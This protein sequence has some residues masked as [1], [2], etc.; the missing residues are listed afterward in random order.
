MVRFD[1]INK[2]ITTA[3]IPRDVLAKSTCAQSTVPN[4]YV[5]INSIA[6]QI[7]QLPDKK[8]T[9]N[10]GL[11]CLVDSLDSNY[12]IKINEVVRVNFKAVIDLVDQ[13]GGLE[14]APDP[15][16][17]GPGAEAGFCAQDEYGL[18]DVYC[19]KP[20]VSQKFT[21]AQALAYARERKIDSDFYRGLRQQEIVFQ[22][23]QKMKK[24]L[25]VFT[26][27]PTI[28]ESVGNNMITTFT[29][30]IVNDITTLATSASGYQTKSLGKLETVKIGF[31]EDYEITD[32]DLL[33]LEKAFNGS[34][35]VTKTA[36]ETTEKKGN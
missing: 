15:A 16:N 20:G 4:Q 6:A 17:F 29:G 14:F 23:S 27:I 35:D 30:D 19:F 8:A 9:I 5:K 32:A 31:S 3:T 33:K 7:K 22:I 1:P 34:E 10:S 12:K 11:N 18:E 21:G 13:I 2:K 26:K 28:I 36:P 24:D 25:T